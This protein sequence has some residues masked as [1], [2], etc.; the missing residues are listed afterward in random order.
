MCLNVNRHETLNLCSD[1]IQKTRIKTQVLVFWEDSWTQTCS[2]VKRFPSQQCEQVKLRQ[3]D[4]P[5]NASLRLCCLHYFTALA[6][7][8]L[9]SFLIRLHFL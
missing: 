8:L 4:T 1:L 9:L 6:S 7:F 2:C 5:V 3:I